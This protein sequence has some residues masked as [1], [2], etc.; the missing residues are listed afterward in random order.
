RPGAMVSD[1]YV[2]G[3]PIMEG[4]MATIWSASDRVTGRSVVV[5][6]IHL[7]LSD[8]VEVIQRFQQEADIIA[9]LRSPHIVELLDRGVLAGAPYLVLER[10]EGEDLELRL[11]GRCLSLAECVTLLD[12]VALALLPAHQGGVVHR[13]VKPAN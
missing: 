5:K 4:G 11:R 9:A 12:Q 1:R 8:N 13:D 3:E 10:L 6:S 7:R 2:L